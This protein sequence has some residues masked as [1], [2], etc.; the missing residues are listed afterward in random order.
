MDSEQG[1]IKM[2][3]APTWATWGA[4]DMTQLKQKKCM[5]AVRSSKVTPSPPHCLKADG[6][7]RNKEIL[8]TL[9]TKDRTK[10][11]CS[12]FGPAILYLRTPMIM[13]LTARPFPH[14][15]S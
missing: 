7:K 8:H 14:S 3:Q 13:C 2:K 6:T 1:K 10:D 4:R 11:N 5:K 9:G 15:A 12:D